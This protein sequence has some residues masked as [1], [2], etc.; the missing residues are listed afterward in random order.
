LVRIGGTTA[1][2]EHYVARKF[3]ISLL[4]TCGMIAGVGVTSS[5]VVGAVAT[6]TCVTS[7]IVKTERVY[8]DKLHRYQ[9]KKVVDDKRVCG[10]PKL[11]VALDPSYT[12]STSNPL[13][14]TF[15][16]SASATVGKSTEGRLPP[17]TLDLYID[18]LLECSDNVGGHV[19]GGT[20]EVNPLDPGTY[21]VIT[22][23]NSNGVAPV[24]ATEVDTIPVL[25]TSTTDSVTEVNEGVVNGDPTY[26]FTFTAAV[27]DANGNMVTP[28]GGSIVFDTAAGNLTTSQAGQ[29]TCVLTLWLPVTLNSTTWQYNYGS[30]CLP[31]N[32]GAITIDPQT[33]AIVLLDSTATYMGTAEYSSSTSPAA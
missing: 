23:Y 22:E 26:Q 1:V 4:L 24:S 9:L 27:T 8:N 2:K 6:K 13:D 16:F 33:S 12:R 15:T 31:Y 7:R 21:K 29:T 19:D 5:T 10:T 30:T 17:G 11:H 20:C 32:S 3:L 28:A 14:V 25:S 18:G